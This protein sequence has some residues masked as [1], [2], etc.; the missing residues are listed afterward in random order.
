VR[1]KQFQ[2]VC[3]TCGAT[4]PTRESHQGALRAWNGREGWLDVSKDLLP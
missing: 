3:P 4:G 2:G 1:R